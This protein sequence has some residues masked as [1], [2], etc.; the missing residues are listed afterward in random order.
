MNFEDVNITY[1]LLLAAPVL[2]QFPVPCNSLGP[3]FN[4]EHLFGPKY[5]PSTSLASPLCTPRLWDCISPRARQQSPAMP[6][7]GTPQSQFPVLRGA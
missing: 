2:Q 1:S 3:T 6:D 7:P 5:K 4:A